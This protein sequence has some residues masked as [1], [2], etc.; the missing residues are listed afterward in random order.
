MKGLL[1]IAGVLELEMA[2]SNIYA[3]FLNPY[4]EHGLDTIFA[5]TLCQLMTGDDKVTAEG[6]I[7]MPFSV[8]TEV[9]FIN[10]DKINRIDILLQGTKSSV[11]IENKIRH[12][13]YNNLNA[14]RQF[15][16]SEYI[17]VLSREEV[18]LTRCKKPEE[19]LLKNI[20]HSQFLGKVKE[21]KD[22][23][24]DFHAK[25]LFDELCYYANTA[26]DTREP[27]PNYKLIEQ[28]IMRLNPQKYAIKHCPGRWIHFVH[29][30]DPQA[31]ICCF[32]GYLLGEEEL[33]PMAKKQMRQRYAT[34]H[35]VVM[36]LQLSG[37]RIEVFRKKHKQDI[38]IAHGDYV[39][40]GREIIGIDDVSDYELITASIKEKFNEL[41]QLLEDVINN[42]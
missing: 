37:S 22:L 9:K 3:Y 10:N 7:G 16:N 23:S 30:K 26:K 14:Y 11:V 42:M 38:Q 24:A 5:D 15:D 20:L 31:I 28:S 12:C 8:R 32:Y 36:C 40:F 35:C 18:E 1:E 17:V 41:D 39:Q 19:G 13:L 2:W 27:A 6:I 25:Q 29:P 21:S 33:A 34:N 4:E